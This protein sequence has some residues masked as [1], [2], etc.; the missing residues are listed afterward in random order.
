MAS[1]VDE[2]YDDG[3]IRYFA[4]L[5]TYDPYEDSPNRDAADEELGFNEGDVI[6]VI[7]GFF[8]FF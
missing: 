8:F 3:T 7:A 6:K 1:E 5:Y 2:L 4:A